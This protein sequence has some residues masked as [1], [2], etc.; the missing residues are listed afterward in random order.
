MHLQNTLRLLHVAG[1]LAK[2]VLVAE[3]LTQVQPVAPHLSPDFGEDVG[4]TF[5]ELHLRLAAKLRPVHVLLLQLHFV[6]L[7]LCAQVQTEFGLV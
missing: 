6:L 3:L 5:A 4:H 2:F 1:L 7:S